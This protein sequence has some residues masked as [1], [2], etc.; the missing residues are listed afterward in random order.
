MKILNKK[1]FAISLSFILIILLGFVSFQAYSHSVLY[2]EEMT[3]QA[4]DNKAKKY[5]D[6]PIEDMVYR[7]FG[8]IR[9][10]VFKNEEAKMTKQRSIQVAKENKK[11]MDR[12]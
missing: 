7:G 10:F 2:D 11:M 6:E 8:K 9:S 12:Y 3:R 4:E 5:M 1:N